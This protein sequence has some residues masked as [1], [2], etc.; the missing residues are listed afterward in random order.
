M[1]MMKNAY[2]IFV[3]N[4]KKNNQL[5]RPD[6]DGKIILKWVLQK[7]SVRVRAGFN[8]LRITS[9]VRS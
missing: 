2:A 1:G 9:N 6:T 7:Q 3:K 4:P 8:C 5:V